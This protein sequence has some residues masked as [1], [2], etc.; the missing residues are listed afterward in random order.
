MTSQTPS[1]SKIQS[2]LD[3]IDD[4]FLEHKIDYLPVPD[5]APVPFELWEALAYDIALSSA[6]IEQIAASY[7]I[8]FPQISMLKEN[9]TFKRMLAVKEQEVAQL[10]SNADFTVK[11]RMIANK[12]AKKLLERIMRN[13]TS[14]KDFAT[15]Y[16]Q[17]VQLA[18]L[19]PNT[20]NGD[21]DDTPTGVLGSGVTFNL[22][23]IP[24]LDH[25]QNPNL[26]PTQ[27]V[28]IDVTPKP[29]TSDDLDDEMESL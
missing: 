20:S 12:G 14:D 8:T 15:L 23:S 13:D 18:Q 7:N 24:G 2:Q 17:V 11:M 21:G 22:Y 9:Q 26:P 25:L 19:E 10:G 28:T 3:E 6:P 16:K 29:P 1:I 5:A 4:L 27:T